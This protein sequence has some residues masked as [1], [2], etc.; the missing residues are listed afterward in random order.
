[1]KMCT[2]HFLMHCI[3]LERQS[4]TVC[5][6]AAS[7]HGTDESQANIIDCRDVAARLS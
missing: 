2:Q 6:E 5:T 3:Y 7:S 1:M 4:I